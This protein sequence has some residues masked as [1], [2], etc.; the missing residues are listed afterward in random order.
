MAPL[1]KNKKAVRSGAPVAV[2]AS[3][4]S[5]IAAAN[6]E[7]GLSEASAGNATQA[8][9][10]RRNLRR[11]KLFFIADLFGETVCYGLD[12]NLFENT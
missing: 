9:T 5:P 1:G 2:V 3:P 10:P 8:P 12:C 11:E 4:G 6:V 7:A